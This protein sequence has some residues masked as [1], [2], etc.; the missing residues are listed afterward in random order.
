VAFAQSVRIVPDRWQFDLLRSGSD[1]VLFNITRQGG[2]SSMAA[3]IAL[4]RALYHPKSL[5]LCLAPALCQS[6]ELFT[7]IATFYR[8]LDQPFAP[9]AGEGVIPIG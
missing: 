2:K 4:D 9:L 1:R 6:Q 3:I 8:E 5:I 7:K